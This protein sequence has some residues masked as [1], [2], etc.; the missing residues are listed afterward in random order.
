MAWASG[1]VASGGADSS[2]ASSPT[3]AATRAG[4]HVPVLDGLRGFAVLYVLLY[5]FVSWF[6]GTLPGDMVSLVFRM[7]WSGVDLFF[8]LSGFLITGILHKLRDEPDYFR[9]FYVRRILRIFPVYYLLVA[10]C[11]WLLPHVVSDLGPVERSHWYWLYLSNFDTELALPFHPYLCVAWSLSIE[12]Q[13]Y[14][15]YPALVWRLSYRRWI[16]LLLGLVGLSFAL[17]GIVFFISASVPSTSII[18]P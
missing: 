18:S 3:L 7:G 11:V 4:E 15:V 1:R 8:V 5:H 9:Q 16:L 12:E 17:R 13:Y 2:F 10:L 14:V 6:H